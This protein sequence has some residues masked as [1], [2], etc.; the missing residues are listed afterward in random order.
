MIGGTVFLSILGA[1]T[2]SVTSYFKEKYYRFTERDAD[3]S[4]VKL[5]KILAKI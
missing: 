4:K 3:S 5:T 1:G 2:F